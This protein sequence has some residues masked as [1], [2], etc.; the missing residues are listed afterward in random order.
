MVHGEKWYL[1]KLVYGNLINC[2]EFTKPKTIVYFSA[3]YQSKKACTYVEMRFILLV[4]T[5]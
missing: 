2:Q 1:T 5:V 4:V 3:I